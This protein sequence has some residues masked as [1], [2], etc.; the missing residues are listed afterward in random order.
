MLAGRRDSTFPSVTYDPPSPLA[1][2]RGIFGVALAIASVA[3]AVLFLAT[4]K[5]EWK[6]LALVLLLWV[7]WGVALDLFHTVLSPLGGFFL[8]LLGGGGSAITIEEETAYLE[9]LLERPLEPEK[10]V[11]TGLRLAEIYR[12]HQYNKPKADALIAR[13]LAKYP[14]APELRVYRR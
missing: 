5:V 12:V 4:G 3:L 6:L 7:L 11:L 1:V 14:D 8:D 13:L 10:E 2:V 9:G